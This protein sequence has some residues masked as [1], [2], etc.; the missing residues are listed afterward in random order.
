[1]NNIPGERA[2]EVVP[3]ENAPEDCWRVIAAA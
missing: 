3:N 1:V 2:L